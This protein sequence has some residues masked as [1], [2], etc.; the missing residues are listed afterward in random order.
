M[1]NM[2]LRSGT[3][4]FILPDGLGG[5]NNLRS[6]VGCAEYVTGLLQ[7]TAFLEV[8]HSALGSWPIL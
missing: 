5:F 7:L 1:K 2:A 3:H 8:L 4:Q 6:E